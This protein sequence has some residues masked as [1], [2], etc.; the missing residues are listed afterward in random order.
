MTL[1]DNENVKDIKIG[2]IGGGSRYWAQDFMCDLAKA[3]NISGKVYLYDIDKYAAKCNETIGNGIRNHY[4]NADN[5]DYIAVDTYEE[6]LSGADAVVISILPGTFDEMEVDVHAA[7]EYGIVQSVGDTTGIGG[8]IRALR[9]LPMFF[10]FGEQI[11]KYCPDAFVINYTNPMA[12]CTGALY[13][14]FP[15]I[16]C[17]GCCHEVFSSQTLLKKILEEKLGL[18]DI[19]RE[20]IKINVIGVNH[21]TWI[22]EA[23]YHNI[24]LFPLYREYCLEHIEK[25]VPITYEITELNKHFVHNEKVKMDLFLR[26]GFM[27]AAGDRHLAEFCPRSWYLKDKETVKNYGFALTPVSWRKSHLVERL[28]K[29]DR[30]LSGEE[31]FEMKETGEEGVRQL[32]ALF[33]LDDF[34]TNVNLPNMG[35]IPNLPLGAIVETNARFSAG[36]V[37]PVFAGNIPKELKALIDKTVD[38]QELIME[39]AYER[40][41]DKAF[42]AFISEE[43]NTLD[44][45]QSRELFDKMIEGTKEYLKDYLK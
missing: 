14:V 1:V 24:D 45:K 11:K 31:I 23:H 16:K 15:E 42:I 10:E 13:K 37:R 2:F 17:F 8:I 19:K 33:G 3:N 30:L 22:T 36:S 41:L 44:L 21:F 7:E 29:R 25:G 34:V 32:S 9:T 27:A 38:I 28:E 6:A 12:L 43:Q 26:F 4:E 20:D 35:Q 5:F 18:T 39:A 40:D